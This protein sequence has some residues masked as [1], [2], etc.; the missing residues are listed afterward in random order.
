MTRAVQEHTLL[1]LLE[2]Q[3]AASLIIKDVISPFEWLQYAE[4][5]LEVCL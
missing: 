2:K 5:C 3:E 4:H 1:D